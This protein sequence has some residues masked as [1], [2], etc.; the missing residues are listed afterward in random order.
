AG[1]P[2]ATPPHPLDPEQLWRAI[3]AALTEHADRLL[4]ALE[5]HPQTNEVARSGILLPGFLTIA[6]ATERSLALLELGASAGLNLLW[7]RFH[8]RY[9]ER[10]WGDRAAPVSLAPE[11][12]GRTPDLDAVV[13]VV[14]RHGV[15][16]ARVD[17][18]NADD[19]LRLRSYIWADQRE[20]LARLDGALAIAQELALRIDGGDAAEWLERALAARRER[21]ATGVFHPIVSHFAP[22]PTLHRVKAAPP[23]AG[24]SPASG[25]PRPP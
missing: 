14:A 25:R 4:G 18:A 12:R 5:R 24:P 9:G 17:V 15:D 13:G 19:R 22:R 11:L 8:Y 2:A 7:D 20:R 16:L 23:R 21:A 3:A 10:E 6:R 1:V